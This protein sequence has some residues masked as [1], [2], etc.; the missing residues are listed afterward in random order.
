MEGGEKE[1]RCKGVPVRRR[2]REGERTIIE[3]GKNRERM[4][5]NLY[6]PKL[7]QPTV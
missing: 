6:I 4:S 7:I 5:E 3:G 2:K 1:Q